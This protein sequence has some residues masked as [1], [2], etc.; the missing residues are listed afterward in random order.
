MPDKLQVNN[1]VIRLT[2]GDITLLEVDGFVFYAQH[3]LQLGSG[4]GTAVSQRGGPRIQTELDEIGGAATTEVV[5][6]GAGQLAAA[7]ILHA[8]GPRFQEPDLEAKL[9]ATVLNCMKAADAE[10]LRSVAFP[11]MGAGFYG[12]PLPVSAETTLRAARD[13]LCQETGIEEV[14]VCLLDDREYGPF[15][16]RLS[17]LDAA[18][19]QS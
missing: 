13:Y 18:A 5:V 12:V 15:A 16:E 11:A 10:G 2:K 3:D 17:A 19:A 9:R 7:K 6:S 4:F 14:V 1:R 8:V